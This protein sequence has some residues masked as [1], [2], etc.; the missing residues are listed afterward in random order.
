MEDNLGSLLYFILVFPLSPYLFLFCAHA[1][2][3]LVKKKVGSGALHGVRICRGAPRISQLFFADDTLLFGRA[4]ATELDCVKHTLD[5]Y[6][7]ASGQQGL[8]WRVGT[9]SQIRIR[10]DPWL[11]DDRGEVIQLEDVAGNGVHMVADLINHT[12]REWNR[13]TV[14]NN[15]PEVIAEH[16]IAIPLGV[17]ELND[18]LFWRVNQC[19]NEQQQ[20]QVRTGSRWI[21][22]D[23]GRLK[24]NSDASVRHGSGTG[25]A[26]VLRDSEGRVVWCY[27]EKYPVALDV[28]LAEATAIYRGLLLAQE[29]GVSDLQVESDSQILINAITKDRLDLSYFGRL[30]RLIVD[31][32]KSFDRVSFSWT[33]RTGNLVAHRLASFAFSCPVDFFHFAIPETLVPVVNVDCMA[34]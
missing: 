15:F 18:T 6:A 2:S 9:G 8:S 4:T 12:T 16:V 30:V 28:D 21:P 27:A 17:D 22:P 3:S 29:H 7:Q 10:E 31:L 11:F 13:E 20:Q 26:G 24:L 1:L 14:R 19:M 5:T 23:C 32:S 25:I 34:I 33:R